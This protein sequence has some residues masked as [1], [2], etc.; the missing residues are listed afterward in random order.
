MI[1]GVPTVQMRLEGGITGQFVVDTGSSLAVLLEPA[2]ARLNLHLLT[3]R[4]SS[5]NLI[6]GIG[7]IARLQT[8]QCNWVELAGQRLD[9]T[10]DVDYSL[11]SKSGATL[12]AYQSGGV[13]MEILRSFALTFDYRRKEFWAKRSRTR[14]RPE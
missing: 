2:C 1:G 10:V 3:S 4:T 8:I 9:R 13:G 6:Y 5:R 14:S 7:G 11:D 12:S